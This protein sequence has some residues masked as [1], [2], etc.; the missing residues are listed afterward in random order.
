MTTEA[1]MT[2]ID[3]ISRLAS[4]GIAGCIIGRALYE[5]RI[6]LSAAVKVARKEVAEA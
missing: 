5:G 1:L 3:D 6:D 4:R 2:T